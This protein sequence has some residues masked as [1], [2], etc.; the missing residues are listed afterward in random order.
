M[1]QGSQVRTR[2]NDNFFDQEPAQETRKV[3]TAL[4]DDLF[5]NDLAV[6]YKHT[7]LH[8]IEESAG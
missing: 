1:P 7:V 6:E 5:I 3:L 4:R 8:R 2:L